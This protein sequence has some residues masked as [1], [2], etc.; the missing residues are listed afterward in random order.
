MPRPMQA[1]GF[2]LLELLVVVFI[3][4]ILATMFTLSVGLL[5][6]DSELDKEINRLRALIELAREDAVTQGHE[7]GLHFYPDS[8]EFAVYQEDFVDYYDPDDE[9]QD[10]S[11][12]IV[13]SLGTLLK[14]RQLPAG[15]VIELEIDDRDIVLK[16]KQETQLEAENNARNPNRVRIDE[17]DPYRPQIWLF[18]SGD[19]SPFAIRF[20]REFA[21]EGVT[22]Q[23]SEDG[24]VELIDQ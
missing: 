21:N 18:S 14:P 23:Y 6:S 3:I 24:S 1:S 12:W 8:Y 15:I 16:N 22:L 5:G 19:I 11:E 9:V 4:G 17:R 2:S 13:L 10:Q 20:R 7:L